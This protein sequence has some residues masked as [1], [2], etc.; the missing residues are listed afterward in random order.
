MK[1]LHQ[2]LSDNLAW[3]KHWHETGFHKIV[4]YGLLVFTV[5]FTV[6][7]II[8]STQVSAFNTYYIS[9]TG[10]NSA[11]GT[12]SA[13]WGLTKL[14]SITLNPGDIVYLRGG[15]YTSTKGASAYVHL[16]IHDQHGASGNMITIANYP[17][18]VP[19]FDLYNVGFPTNANP[20]GVIL[21]NSTYVDL[22][23]LVI[24]NLRQAH[25]GT[26]GLGISRG[27][28]I[29]NSDNNTVEQLNV[30]NIAGTG[31]NV[32]NSNNNLILNNDSHHNG[33]GYD[34]GYGAWNTG[35]GFSV[36]TGGDTS[37]GNTFKGNRMYLNSDDGIDSF[38]WAGSKITYI[39]NWSFWNGVKPWKNNIDV[40]VD[41]ANTTSTTPTASM[42]PGG[43]SNIINYLYS[44]PAWA[45]EGFKLGGHN[46]SLPNIGDPNSLRKFVY[47][48]VSFENTGGGFQEN[49]DAVYAHKMQLV[50]NIAWGNGNDGFGFGAGRSSNPSIAHIFMNN[51][52]WNNNRGDS[53]G[54]F[55]FDGINGTST[56]NGTSVPSISTNY[57]HTQY[58]LNFGNLQSTSFQIAA[59]DFQSLDSTGV[60]GPRQADGSLPNLPF[61]KLSATSK[62]IDKGTIINNLNGVTIPFNGTKPDLGAYEY[63]TSDTFAPTTS[64]TSP[65][66]GTTV[67]GTT[68]Q[69]AANA[70]DNVGVTKV[71]FYIDGT[72]TLLNCTPNPDTTSPY[73]CI[74]NTTTVSNGTH[75]ITSKAYDAAGNSGISSVVSVNVQNV[76]N[77]PPVV[78]VIA[79]TSGSTIS[80]SSVTLSANATDNNAMQKVE[81]YQGSTLL[82]TQ[83]SGPGSVFSITWNT[84]TVANGTYSITAKAYDTA[85][86]TPNVATSTAINLIVSNTTSGGTV[87]DLTLALSPNPI[88]LSTQGG[89]ADLSINVKE[90]AG[91]ATTAPITIRIPKISGFSAALVTSP[92]WTLDSSNSSYYTLSSSAIIPAS[93]TSPIT[94]RYTKTGTNSSK[95]TISVRIRTPSGGETNTT[96]N[97][98]SVIL[99]AMPGGV[100]QNDT[101]TANAGPDQSITLPTN[102][103]TLSGSGTDIDGTI[104]TYLWTRVSGSGTITTPNQATTTITGLTQGTSVFKLKVT[105]N[106][107]GT[108]TDNVSVVVGASSGSFAFSPF[109][110]N[111]NSG[112]VFAPSIAITSPNTIT[113]VDFYLDT[114]YIGHDISGQ[115]PFDIDGG[116]GYNSTQIANGTYSLTAKATDNLG[117]TATSPAVSVTISN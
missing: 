13:P 68:Q 72:T 2:H 46:P 52:A 81:F 80:G 30:Y 1:K 95:T 8:S 21:A 104:S 17:G 37:T 89:T 114:T 87:P 64:L 108:G 22:K 5:L 99:N 15:I 67:L 117:N 92:N 48:N 97:L 10:S 74:W 39:G 51:I 79:P 20:W 29:S 60:D 62:F 33:E 115:S 111:Q 77:V 91:K 36:G 54:D 94:M 4:H 55:V 83:T 43:W 59:S 101:P 84:T 38:D 26:T 93:G 44:T 96:N 82:G 27:F 69:V 86:P 103:V 28:L 18:E 41:A 85:S 116:T 6:A 70:T 63:G 12:I 76:D 16:N 78:S 90:I 35:D 34:T 31:F 53:G 98:A 100:T 71:E 50:N 66:T 42:T 88:L 56:T 11:S 113:T 9:P 14:E 61:L 32:E 75:T 110:I 109:V 65:T 19:I 49:M 102:S 106:Q 3:Y 105:D 23:G 58:Q 45:G 107:G 7:S 47:N 40:P 73:L 112:G 25:S 24:R 57:W